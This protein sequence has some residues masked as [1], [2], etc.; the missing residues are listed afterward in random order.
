MG[1]MKETEEETQFADNEMSDLAGVWVTL[2]I[3]AWFAAILVAFFFIGPVVGIVA[4]LGG[5]VISL[6]LF[7]RFIRRSDLS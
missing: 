1:S 3:V 2:W 6:L 5:A 4:V 7:V